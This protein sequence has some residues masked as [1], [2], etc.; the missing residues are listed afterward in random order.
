MA[1]KRPGQNLA[2]TNN[3]HRNQTRETTITGVSFQGPI[4]PPQLLAQYNDV[5]PDA[6]ERIL[7]MAENQSEHRMGLEKAVIHSDIKR[8]F[9]GLAAGFTVAMSGM[10]SSFALILNNH[11]LEGSIL[12]GGVLV[13]LVSTFVTGTYSK[14]KERENKAKPDK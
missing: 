4:P 7:R 1:R 11:S 5:I 8:S 6:A 3:N 14:R 9:W 13:T 2:T 12:G 10:A